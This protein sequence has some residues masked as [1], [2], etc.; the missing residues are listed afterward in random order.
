MLQ[1]LMSDLADCEKVGQLPL[2]HVYSFSKADTPAQDVQ[3][4]YRPS[5]PLNYSNISGQVQAYY[6]VKLF[7]YFRLGDKPVFCE[8]T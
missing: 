8:I 2:V 7:K 4:R 3:A 6:S 5:I 1:G